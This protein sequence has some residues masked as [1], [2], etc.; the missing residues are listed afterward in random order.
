MKGRQKKK[1]KSEGDVQGGSR[2]SRRSRRRRSKRGSGGDQSK[3]TWKCRICDQINT[4]K[5]EKCK[6][7]GRPR[8]K[9]GKDHKQTV[10]VTKTSQP[11]A[12]SV[13][14]LGASTETQ[15]S[16]AEDAKSDNIKS[17][18][19]QGLLSAAVIGLLAAAMEALNK[20]APAGASLTDDFE[21][22]SFQSKKTAIDHYRRAEVAGKCRYSQQESNCCYYSVRNAVEATLKRKFT[23]KENKEF[24]K[25]K[26]DCPALGEFFMHTL[27]LFCKHFPKIPVRFTLIANSVASIKAVVNT[28]GPVLITIANFNWDDE[29]SEIITSDSRDAFDIH[30]CCCVGNCKID[31]EEYLVFKDSNKHPIPGGR[32]DNC[33]Q[34]LNIKNLKYREGRPDLYA[35]QA[36]AIK[37]TLGREG[38]FFAWCYSCE[39]LKE[40]AA[41][42]PVEEEW[43]YPLARAILDSGL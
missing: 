40:G 32:R 11:K 43:W 36:G 7:C 20:R 37:N 22:S 6:T 4:I 28:I 18:L 21:P 30:C 13:V 15:W 12:G 26:K 14:D 23:A 35:M 10:K 19:A 1:K 3:N 31:G 5:G 27:N 33:Y 34:F 29:I 9:K 38:L 2:R 41:C 24:N 42:I 16:L 17:N 8:I 39:R 25:Y